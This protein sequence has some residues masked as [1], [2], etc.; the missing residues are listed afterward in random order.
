MNNIPRVPLRVGLFSVSRDS[1]KKKNMPRAEER[2][3]PEM[4]D[5]VFN[6]HQEKRMVL[7]TSVVNS[8]TLK[9]CF[10]LPEH[11]KFVSCQ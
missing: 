5:Q 7:V 8:A 1:L 9:A 10:L 6:I 11:G 4:M 3:L 2:C